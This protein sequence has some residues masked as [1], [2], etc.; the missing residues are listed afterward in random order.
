MRLRSLVGVLAAVASL[1]VPGAAQAAGYAVHFSEVLASGAAGDHP[2]ATLTA[3]F[4][5][6]AGGTPAPT[7]K[8][9]FMVDPRHLD[10]S[11]LGT[12]TTAPVG[13][14]IGYATS[15][16]TGGPGAHLP[17]TISGPPGLTGLPVS[18]AV[19]ANLAPLVGATI[20]ASIVPGAPVQVIVDLTSA[21][22][23]LA[24]AGVSLAFTQ[25]NVTFFGKVGNANL[26]TN[27][28][29]TTALTDGVSAQPCVSATCSLGAS[30]S[31]SGTLTLPNAVQVTAPGNAT[32]GQ[33]ARFT[34]SAASG[35]TIQLWQLTAAGY[36]KIAGATA[37]AGS[38]GSYTLTAR[39]RSQF[40]TK[41]K[42]TLPATGTY[43]V[44]SSADGKAMVVA[45][46]GGATTVSLAKP[47]VTA[48]RIGHTNRVRVTVTDAG[49]DQNVA[50]KVGTKGGKL[51]LGG[52]FTATITIKKHAK[53]NAKVSVA[54]ALSAST[55]LKV[56]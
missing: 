36:M 11:A 20:P 17:V 40:D 25:V 52:R 33:A 39:L 1:V 27:P 21:N 54:G 31:D 51:G 8:I 16:L 4:D 26:I 42:L 37:T 55:S 48:K 14:A 49:G 6:G 30:S 3:T 22:A 43:A 19:P 35:T 46:A 28:S 24:A 18:I 50:V 38:N 32:Y 23:K 2:D 13:T 45:D 9:V 7:G 41:H 5:D 44:T 10:P 29:T 34:G 47:K 15:N 53:L 56:K 12:L